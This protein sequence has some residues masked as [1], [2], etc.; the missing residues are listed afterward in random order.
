MFDNANIDERTLKDRRNAIHAPVRVIL[1]AYSAVV[2]R[3]LQ[4]G[5]KGP[6]ARE[7]AVACTAATVSKMTGITVLPSDVEQVIALSANGGG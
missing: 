1:R 6:L 2:L 5:I 3:L 7:N 4:R